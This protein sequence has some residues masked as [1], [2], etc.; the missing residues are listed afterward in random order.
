MEDI[1]LTNEEYPDLPIADRRDLEIGRFLR[2]FGDLES[3]VA[4]VT[5]VAMGV[6]PQDGPQVTRRLPLSGSLDL[7]RGLAA[8]RFVP[9]FASRVIDWAD[10]V[11]RVAGRRNFVVHSPW[12]S[13]PNSEH[14]PAEERSSSRSSA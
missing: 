14:A 3:S 12:V 9:E 1:P 7:L 6:A 13:S 11:D 4:S 2:R 5:W 10:R 8:A